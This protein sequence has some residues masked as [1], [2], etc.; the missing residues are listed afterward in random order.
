MPFD[1]E[2]P[3]TPYLPQNRFSLPISYGHAVLPLMP[4]S[5]L[6]LDSATHLAWNPPVNPTSEDEIDQLEFS[7]FNVGMLCGKQSN[8][9][10]LEVATESAQSWIY[11]Q[12]LLN[13]PHWL[14]RSARYYLFNYFCTGQTFTEIRAGLQLLN[15]GT[16]VIYPGSIYDDGRAVY[17]EDSPEFTEVAHLPEWLC[18]SRKQAENHG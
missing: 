13:T 15:D 14:T 11:E 5:D 7:P 16:F 8:V 6:P 17:W 3:P 2:V 10:V 12:E 9:T 18:A 1:D 4:G